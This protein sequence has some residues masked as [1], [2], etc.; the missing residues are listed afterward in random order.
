VGTIQMANFNN[1][2]GLLKLGE[3]LYEETDASGACTTGCPGSNGFGKI[4]Q[5]WIEKSNVDLRQVT[6]EWKRMRQTC[7]AIRSLLEGP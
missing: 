2:Q 1:S 5:G 7:R 3:N 6:A 4:R